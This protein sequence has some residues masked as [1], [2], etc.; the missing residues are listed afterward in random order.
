MKIF[1]LHFLFVFILLSCNVSEESLS[2]G[3]RSV[4]E[5]DSTNN[6]VAK[7]Y[8]E[9]ADGQAINGS[10]VYIITPSNEINLLNFNYDIGC[11][12][13]SLGSPQSGNYIIK[14]ESRAYGSSTQ[15]IQFES[16]GS[17]I[18]FMIFQDDSGS[19]ALLGD[20][21]NFDSSFSIAWTSIEPVTVYTF[22]L[23]KPD[24]SIYNV[25]T[26]ESSV[27]INREEINSSGNYSVQITAQYISGDPLFIDFDYYAVNELKSSRFYFEVN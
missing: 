13:E 27:L 26:S 14:A 17:S 19:D 9:G 4:I 24:G 1:F 7:V 22:I 25:S 18:E 11:F 5:S 15:D 10:L 21:L 6:M 23:V 2:M 8:L 20:N 16:L 3:I 12:T